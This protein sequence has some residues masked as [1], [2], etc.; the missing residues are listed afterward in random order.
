MRRIGATLLGAVGLVSLVGTLACNQELS[1][2][3]LGRRTYMGR[4]IQCHNPNPQADGT[5]GPAIAGSSRELIEARVL[6][7]G[8][9]EGYM[10]KRNTQ[11][12]PAQPDLVLQIDNLAAFLA[13][14]SAASGG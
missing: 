5:L 1:P 13:A 6:R 9:P 3:E 4:C 10:P 11:A 12:M 14:A 2:A 7:A 8:Y